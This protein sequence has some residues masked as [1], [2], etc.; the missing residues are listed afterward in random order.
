MSAGTGATTIIGWK[1]ST[2]TNW[3]PFGKGAVL[4]SV[5][6]GNNGEFIWGLG[7]RLASA[8]V[9]KEYEVSL[10]IEF[11]LTN[12]WWVRLLL[13]GYSDI[14]EQP[15]VYYPASSIP[16]FNILTYNSQVYQE[17]T[18]TNCKVNSATFSLS[19]NEPVKVKLE[20]LG[21]TDSITTSGQP[22]IYTD[23]YPLY[24]CNA[25]TFYIDSESQTRFTNWEITV[26]NNLEKKTN[27]GSR[28][29]VYI[30]EKN[31]AVTGALSGI[32]VDNAFLKKLY[33]STNAN[34]P[35]ISLNN[36]G[37]LKA[38][39]ISGSYPDEYSIVVGAT[40]N[41]EGN[42]VSGSLYLNTRGAPENPTE[43]MVE[44]LDYLA[45]KMGVHVNR[46]TAEPA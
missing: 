34:S 33:G 5:S 9:A 30:V 29:P 15:I 18:Y 41:S 21:K 20:I 37:V 27:L 45:D 16:S 35:E 36:L 31:L 32:V 1:E 24:V 44:D 3:K 26:N 6:R 22:T 39:W 10:S 42:N 46:G 40:F 38:E 19:A 13:G 17:I 12:P 14:Q 4:T 11:L 43:V 28:T 7:D 2:Q 23:P 8:F 25:M